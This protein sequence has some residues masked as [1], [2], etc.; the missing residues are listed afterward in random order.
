M[1]A[2]PSFHN[3]PVSED[4]IIPAIIVDVIPAERRDSSG[5]DSSHNDT[6]PQKSKTGLV[7]RLVKKK[8]DKG[9]KG[10]DKEKKLTKV[11]YM[12]RKEYVTRFLSY[13]SFLLIIFGARISDYES[14]INNLL[15]GT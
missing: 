8:K 12:P 10:D 15:Q 14:W 1:Y 2:A 13:A 5:S 9:R 11:V 7:S 3:T 4:A 6:V